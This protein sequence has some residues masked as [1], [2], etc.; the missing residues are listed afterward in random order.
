MSSKAIQVKKVANVIKVLKGGVDFYQA[1]IKEIDKSHLCEV[2]K[3]MVREKRE[4][5]EALQPFA[6][7]EEGEEEQDSD[8]VIKT[9]Q[10]YTKLIG[11]ISGNKSHTYIKQLE[12]VEDRVLDA[13][14]DALSERQPPQC[15]EVLRPIRTKAQSMH[16]EMKALQESTS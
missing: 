16:D 4:A 13:L 7:S 3:K 5:I 2:F 14:D 1:A 15:L 8:C 9:R 6:I 12:E 11:S 10:M